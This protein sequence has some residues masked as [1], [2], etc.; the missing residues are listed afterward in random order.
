MNLST[1]NMTSSFYYTDFILFAF[2]GVT[3]FR[4]LLALPFSSIYTIILLGN[5]TVMTIIVLERNLHS[6]MYVLIW[7]LLAINVLYTTAITPKMILALVGL[8]QISLSGCL[9][10]M[11]IVYSNIMAES[12]VVLLM[13][14]D[15][16]LAITWPLHYQE[17]IFKHLLAHS[18]VNM[19]VRICCAVFP[20]V[21][22]AARLQYCKSNVIHH[23]HCESFVLIKL[24]CDDHTMA[25]IIGLLIRTLITAFDITIIFLSYLK[26]VYMAMKIAVGPARHKALHTC[27]TH[28][29]VVVLMYSSGILSVILYFPGLSTSYTGQNIASAVYF[30]T[31]AIVNPFI[32]G[33]RMMEIK[34]SLVRFWKNK[35][36]DNALQHIKDC[37]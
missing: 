18:T 30:L 23:F 19:V 1:Q 29:A 15:R 24:A 17:V 3:R 20:L 13:A 37:H 21:I 4:P 11:F 16:Y 35:K 6:P 27:A 12:V 14:I 26:I 36:E 31:P 25:P 34:T 33:L 5:S 2:P 22:V 28:L 32:Y 8:N 7:T 10:Q 9:M